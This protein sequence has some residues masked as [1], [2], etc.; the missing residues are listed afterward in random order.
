VR[1]ESLYRRYRLLSVFVRFLVGLL[2][3]LNKV[4]VREYCLVVLRLDGVGFSVFFLVSYVKCPVSEV[5][6]Q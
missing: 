1:L 4:W 6:F 2:S 5:R 3:I